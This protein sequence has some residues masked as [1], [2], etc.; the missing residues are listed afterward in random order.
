MLARHSLVWL[1]DAGWQ[2]A[3]NSA[4]QDCREIIA[5]W[6]RTDWPAIARRHDPEATQEQACLGIAL[7][8]D[9]VDGSKKRIPVRVSRSSIRKSD[10]PPAL[11]AVLAAAPPDWR[12]PLAALDANARAAGICLRVY[13][14]LALQAFTGQAYLTKASDIDLLFA[15]HSVA[16]LSRGLE[17]LRTYAGSLP[18]DGEILFPAGQAVAW[19]EWDRAQTSGGGCRVLVKEMQAVRLR[20]LDELLSLL[21]TAPWPA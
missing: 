5:A 2:E 9:S 12:E 11:D 1:T 7:P 18:L 16:S 14:S 21:E 13:G 4:P 19:K 8:P 3:Q 20:S 15:P 10:A 17:L 6:K